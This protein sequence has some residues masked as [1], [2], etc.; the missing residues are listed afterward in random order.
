MK[1]IKMLVVPALIVTLAGCA[2][3]PNQDLYRGTAIGAVLGAAAGQAIGKDTKST[4]IGA[5]VGGLAGAGV[6]AYM[7]RQRIALEEKLKAETQAKELVIT[8]L[9]EDTIKIGIA[10]DVS[11]EAGSAQLQADSLNTFAKIASVIKDYDKTVVH[12]VGHTDTTG[13]DSFNQSLSERRASTVATYIGGQGVNGQRMRTEGRGEREPLVRTPDNTKEPRNRR[14][15]IIIKAIID[16]REQEAYT[17]PPYL[18]G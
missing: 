11:F 14:V 15:D 6:G 5:V 16:G 7:D 10:S 3:D 4:V 12:V 2:G 1:S 9:S 8:K 17:P 18:G 13:S